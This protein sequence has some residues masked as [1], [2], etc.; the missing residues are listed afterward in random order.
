MAHDCNDVI[1][2]GNLMAQTGLDPRR[3]SA[4]FGEFIS[5]RDIGW[6]SSSMGTLRSG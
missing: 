2:A 3:D 5:F 6:I 1:P 4:G